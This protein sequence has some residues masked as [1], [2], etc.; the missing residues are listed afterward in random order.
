MV[1]GQ[2]LKY[3]NS[4]DIP[5]YILHLS[6]LLKHKMSIKTGRKHE[7]KN[8]LLYI[9]VNYNYNAYIYVYA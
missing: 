1:T 7:C 8:L 6:Y 2:K 3:P 5:V 4:A 9:R